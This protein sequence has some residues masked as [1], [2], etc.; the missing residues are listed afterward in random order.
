MIDEKGVKG[1]SLS[2]TELYTGQLWNKKLE[3]PM[4]AHE[5]Y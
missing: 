3:R 5:L 4:E 1:E 2:N